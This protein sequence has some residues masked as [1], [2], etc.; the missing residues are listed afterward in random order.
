MKHCGKCKQTKAL[1]EFHKDK[2]RAD[3][4]QNQCKVC[5]NLILKNWRSPHKVNNEDVCKNMEKL[6]ILMDNMIRKTLR[7]A[8]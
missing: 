7:S 2:N 5:K 4:F 8:A 6:H 3:G 1:S